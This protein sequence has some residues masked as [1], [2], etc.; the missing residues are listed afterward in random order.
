MLGKQISVV[1]PLE[2]RLQKVAYF[3]ILGS[4][5]CIAWVLLTYGMLIRQLLGSGE[6]SELIRV[7]ATT[8]AA[9]M[10]GAE[11]LKLIAIRIMVD[12]LLQRAEEMFLELN[13]AQRWYEGYLVSKSSHLQTEDEQMGDQDLGDDADADGG[14]GIGEDQG[15]TTVMDV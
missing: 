8:L 11:A 1:H 6:E 15:D 5:L 3:L 13:V 2:K 12:V 9:E 10:F 4:W 7:W 14:D